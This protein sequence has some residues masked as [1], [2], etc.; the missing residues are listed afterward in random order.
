MKKSL[1]FL[2]MLMIASIGAFA[3]SYEESALEPSDIMEQSGD[4]WVLKSG[5]AIA[6]C[7]QAKGWE[8]KT[9][10]NENRAQCSIELKKPNGSAYS[11]EIYRSSYV[12]IHFGNKADTTE[13]YNKV[14][15]CKVGKRKWSMNSNTVIL[16]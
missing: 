4:E 11:C 8:V 16:D 9:P 14:K 10:V 7:L 3:Q 12:E 5:T 6:D 15:D 1:L 13:F 2:A